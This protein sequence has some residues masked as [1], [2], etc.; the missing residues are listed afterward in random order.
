VLA[1]G[2]P[3]QAWRYTKLLDRAA[4]HVDAFL[5]PSRFTARMHAERGFLRPMTHLPP[6]SPRPDE[7]RLRRSSPPHPRPYFLFVGRLEPIKGLATL[8]AAWDRFQGPDLVVLGDG[9]GRAEAEA[10]ASR[11]P[12]IIVR[13]A[14]P[15]D[16]VGLYLVHAIAT[17]VP[18]LTY[19]VAPTVVLESF[20]LG[21]PVIGRDLGGT[22]EF[23]LES[24]GGVLFRTDDELLSALNRFAGDP[25][26]AAAM[27]ERGYQAFST[28]WTEDAHLSAYT[29]LVEQLAEE[30][31]G[32]VP[33]LADARERR[34]HQGLSA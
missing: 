25:A 33:W 32:H 28:R 26:A 34:A 13:G 5:T 19:E 4:A 15:P 11:N 3:P 17:L 24:G 16:E 27:G 21:T 20:A 12:R 18:S 8:F 7:D 22:S 2:R 14:V 29:R 23:V 6:F 30:K 1:S 31:L 9:S 10:A